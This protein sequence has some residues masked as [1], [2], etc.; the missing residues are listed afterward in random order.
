MT[1]T[2][3]KWVERIAEWRAGGQTAEEFASGRGFRGSTLR[4]WASRL[5]QHVE[6]QSRAEV[7]MARVRVVRSP[8]PAP[9]VV[10]VVVKVGA[11]SIAVCPGFDR[12]LL[13]DVVD[14]LGGAT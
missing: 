11:A 7:R 3:R 4:F 12:A 10:G 2:E 9:A 13:R 6:A 8:A 5:R 1:E 14:A